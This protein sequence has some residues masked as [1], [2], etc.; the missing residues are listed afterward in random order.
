[1]SSEILDDLDDSLRD[2]DVPPSPLSLRHSMGPSEAAT[3]EDAEADDYEDHHRRASEE[4]LQGSETGSADGYSPPA[5]RRLGNGDRSSG[6]WR[7]PAD[8]LGVLPL[9]FYPT[10]RGTSP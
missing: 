5:W 6:F 3:T 8:G 7:G 1:M 9:P 2:F 10:S 4:D